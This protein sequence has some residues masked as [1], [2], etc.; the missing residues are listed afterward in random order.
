M[1]FHQSSVLCGHDHG[2]L[3][4]AWFLSITAGGWAFLCLA[5]WAW[6]WRWSYK[7]LLNRLG[8]ADLPTPIGAGFLPS[9]R[10]VLGAIFRTPTA[11]ILM[12][13]FVGANFVA[14]IF[15]TMDP[16]VSCGEISIQADDGWVE[17]QRV[18]SSGQR[19]QRADRKERWQI[20]SRAG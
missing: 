4:G 16:D 12:L 7:F 20:G 17:R 10:E 15:L 14:T 1:S 6:C 18:H 11:V 5:P 8:G 3:G 19:V 9:V 2:Q 13:V